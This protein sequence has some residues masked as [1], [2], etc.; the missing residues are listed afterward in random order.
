MQNLSCSYGFSK[1]C[2][3]GPQP[4][5]FIICWSLFGWWPRCIPHWFEELYCIN[6]ISF[7]LLD[8]IL[9]LWLINLLFLKTAGAYD[10]W[11]WRFSSQCLAQA[12]FLSIDFSR[13]VFIH[14]MRESLKLNVL[15]FVQHGNDSSRSESEVKLDG[16]SFPL[17]SKIVETLKMRE[18]KFHFQT[19]CVLAH[20]T[21]RD[22]EGNTCPIFNGVLVSFSFFINFCWFLLH[23]F[24][25]HLLRIIF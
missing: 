8:F 7:F 2:G 16:H 12:P 5:P 1:H 24:Y 9:I 3:N 25:S 15:N 4:N 21:R 13:A 11:F 23:V 10:W 6:E 20:N 22:S 14:S 17:C 19:L 18:E